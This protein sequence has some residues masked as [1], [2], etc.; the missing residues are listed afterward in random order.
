[1]NVFD[2]NETRAD[3][4]CSL[5]PGSLGIYIRNLLMDH[6]GKILSFK[7]HFLTFEKEN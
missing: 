5:K 6:L 4:F 7:P 2:G 1:M 3:T